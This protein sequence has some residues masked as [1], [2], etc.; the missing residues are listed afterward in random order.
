M[1][2]TFNKITLALI[3]QE[4][5]R[6]MTLHNLAIYLGDKPEPIDELA[7]FEFGE[8]VRF[9][10]PFHIAT[11]NDIPTD[12]TNR[13]ITIKG[14]ANDY[15]EHEAVTLLQ[16]PDYVK[17]EQLE[18]YS[19]AEGNTYTYINDDYDGNR[20][21]GVMLS[22]IGPEVRPR[23]RPIPSDDTDTNSDS[24]EHTDGDVHGSV[25]ND[26]HIGGT[27]VAPPTNEL[28][29]KEKTEIPTEGSVD[30]APID[31]EAEQP[32]TDTLGHSEESHSNNSGNT[33]VNR[34]H[35]IPTEDIDVVPEI[36]HMDLPKRPKAESNV[37][38]EDEDEKIPDEP[39]HP[40][41]ERSNG[42]E[43]KIQ[44][45]PVR[46]EPVGP[47]P[48][49]IVRD[50]NPSQPKIQPNKVVEGEH[51]E[52]A[53]ADPQPKPVTPPSDNVHNPEETLT[54]SENH[55]GSENHGESENHSGSENPSNSAD[56]GVN[57]SGEAPTT[58]GAT[59]GAPKRK[60]TLKLIP[61]SVTFEDIIIK[62]I[63]GEYT[64]NASEWLVTGNEG[65]DYEFQYTLKDRGEYVK[66][67]ETLSG[68]FTK[69][70]RI[71]V[72]LEWKD[73]VMHFDVSEEFKQSLEYVNFKMVRIP[74]HF[75]GVTDA[76]DQRKSIRPGESI[77]HKYIGD[78][79]T[80]T[81]RKFGFDNITI[82]AHAKP[83]SYDILF[84]GSLEP[85]LN[86]GLSRFGVS[87]FELE[88]PEFREFNFHQVNVIS[89]TP[90]GT[91]NT[92]TWHSG[93]KTFEVQTGSTVKFEIIDP[94]LT[95][96]RFVS[97]DYHVDENET[98]IRIHE[99]QLPLKRI[100][101]PTWDLTIPN[102][103]LWV[104]RTLEEK[105]YAN[106]EVTINGKPVAIEGKSVTLQ[107]EKGSRNLIKF[108]NKYYTE[109]V[110]ELVI[111]ENT[112][113]SLQEIRE[114]LKIR[115]WPIP[116][117]LSPETAKLELLGEKINGKSVFM[118]GEVIDAEPGLEY[119]M[120]LTAG[121][122]YEGKTFKFFVA[123]E[124]LTI[125]ETLKP[126]VRKK[127][128][129][130]P[131][132]SLRATLTAEQKESFFDEIYDLMVKRHMY[133]HLRI[134]RYLNLYGV[135][136]KGCELFYKHFGKYCVTRIDF[137]IFNMLKSYY[138]GN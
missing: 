65:E 83:E 32:H 123:R 28:S 90:G 46:P 39:P 53:P 42:T 122:D 52:T 134:Y 126:V 47:D 105:P 36:D 125:E 128:E 101:I 137:K 34:K 108:S 5:L 29:T 57:P 16:I 6:G 75:K 50:E 8:S 54:P 26:E 97:E 85:S 35:D 133:K 24:H 10:S 56:N 4:S 130:Y 38:V 33:N 124:G 44:P 19:S 69:D 66:P 107:L 45:A 78:T 61:D 73:T 70:M 94:I 58:N 72:H 110:K 81:F 21:I 82:R 40:E 93:K 15:P 114:G 74:I 62:P 104:P 31:P 51:L 63:R 11:I 41:E 129:V 127:P 23:P 112:V 96:G 103:E 18:T 102:V 84:D 7:S 131:P 71:P 64:Y 27:N 95:D 17:L 13:S 12:A 59:E 2:V 135:N 87:T 30:K 132:N 111:E 55:G 14:K 77:E 119:S 99:S 106:A 1:A 48:K 88:L 116:V 20:N 117:T 49:D 60:V 76:D 120:I 92:Q 89:I 86:N 138:D 79:V 9:D 67:S 98:A 22:Y 109:F 3:A 115:R 136:D 43:P 25:S 68:T 80:I 118:N 121:N 91:V 113:L 37:F 100:P